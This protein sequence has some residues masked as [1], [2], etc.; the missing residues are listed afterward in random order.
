MAAFT[1][2]P[3]PGS[4]SLFLIVL[5]VLS[6]LCSPVLAQVSS[7]NVADVTLNAPSDVRTCQPASI[8]WRWDDNGTPPSDAI[9]LSVINASSFGFSSSSASRKRASRRHHDPEFG[10]SHGFWKRAAIKGSLLP[11]ATAIPFN[12][13]AFRWDQVTVP[14]GLYRLL[15]TVVATGDAVVS[16]PF[17]VLQGS[18]TACIDSGLTA[19]AA[20]GIS[21]LSATQSSSSGNAPAFTQSQ[22][23][24]TTVPASST[25]AD[26]GS[27]TSPT[28]GLPGAPSSSTTQDG[29][30]THPSDSS[31]AIAAGVIVPLAIIAIVAYAASL[32]RKQRQSGKGGD[33]SKG[34]PS[35]SEKFFSDGSKP[36]GAT[37]V[38]AAHQRQISSPQMASA[39]GVAAVA[40]MVPPELRREQDEN[41]LRSLPHC[42]ANENIARQ[43]EDSGWIG[44]EQHE[45]NG[46]QPLSDESITG[47]AL[48]ASSIS[49]IERQSGS[50]P[51]YAQGHNAPL[52]PQSQILSL[53][54]QSES[55]FGSPADRLSSQSQISVGRDLIAALPAPP[56][57]TAHSHK[58]SPSMDRSQTSLHRADSGSSQF[59]I[60]RKPVPHVVVPADKPISEEE[61][62]FSNSHAVSSA[63]H[64]ASAPTIIGPDSAYAQDAAD[65]CAGEANQNQHEIVISA[66]ADARAASPAQ[67]SAPITG[68]NAVVQEAKDY[69]LSVNLARQSAF[70][71]E[72]D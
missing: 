17:T 42:D 31:G 26:S 58:Q 28:S 60:R 68:Q 59:G 9:A 55:S 44:F 67:D 25:P 4:T 29:A 36:S 32:W 33:D 64:V 16:D 11:D 2:C 57:S 39:A 3:A 21:T 62:P 35:W 49:Q 63:T 51:I 24:S 71:V 53:E 12:E 10:K 50:T 65:L 66:V 7:I 13:V 47:R 30:S 45:I 69:H 46:A 20:N 1:G 37:M 54:S 61:D 19:S 43:R 6:A 56:Q 52:R 27:T 23:G 5:G 15:L 34:R 48:S 38:S 72:F 70:M 14:A 22:S 40:R 8:T 41:G 18:N